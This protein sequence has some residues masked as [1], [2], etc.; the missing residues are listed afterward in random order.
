V[1]LAVVVDLEVYLD[2]VPVVI[3]N[4]SP[5]HNRAV[6]NTDI[7]QLTKLTTGNIVGDPYYINPNDNSVQQARRLLQITD[8]I[9]GNNFVAGNAIALT[10]LARA[11]LTDLACATEFFGFTC[12]FG[13][14]FKGVDLRRLRSTDIRRAQQN[15]SKQYGIPLTTRCS[16]SYVVGSE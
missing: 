15:L 1:T 16:Y 9:S 11:I 5:L 7:S 8:Q 10:P 2:L 13:T 14:I 4:N 3:Q 12:P 6:P